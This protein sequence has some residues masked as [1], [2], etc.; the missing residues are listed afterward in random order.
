M[1]SAHLFRHKVEKLN[2]RGHLHL[3]SVKDDRDLARL[4]AQNTEDNY[5]TFSAS[6]G[7]PV[8]DKAIYKNDAS[9]VDSR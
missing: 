1:T 4:I 3:F 9:F 5:S 8:T 6:R 2:T 7:C